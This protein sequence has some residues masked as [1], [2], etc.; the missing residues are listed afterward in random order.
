MRKKNPKVDIY[1]YFLKI[2]SIARIIVVHGSNWFC[3]LQESGKW[4]R[5][6][7]V[8]EGN[9]FQKEKSKR[10]LLEFFRYLLVGG[11]AFLVD[12]GTLVL[13]KEVLLPDFPLKL[14]TA[15]A[16]GF[17]AGLIFNYILSITFVF[18]IAKKSRVGHSFL[19]FVVFTAIG[20]IGLGLTELGMALGV[21][22]LKINYMLVKIMVTA[23][24]LLWN[25]L[26]RK[27]FIFKQPQKE[28]V[29]SHG[30]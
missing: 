8:E 13:C 18:E 14:Y 1:G 23:I 20:V 12:F 30:E 9:M 4:S 19:D 26:G 28:S 16:I 11:S 27:L 29:E 3:S 22:W 25:Y 21:D 10:L 17:I 5:N 15:T 2:V 7:I 6:F 24:V